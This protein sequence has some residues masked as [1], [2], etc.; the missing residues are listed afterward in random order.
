MSRIT[1]LAPI[2]N[3]ESWVG[4][5]IRSLQAQTMK[6]FE[7]LFIDDGSTDDTVAVIESFA[8]D[9]KRIKVHQIPTNKGL[10]N[11]WN[12]G[13]KLVTTPLIA[14]ASGDDIWTPDRAKVTCDYFHNNKVDV[15]Y[16]SF[17]FC[18]SMMNKVEHKPAIAYDKKLLLTPRADGFCPQY[19]GHFV[20]AYTTKIALK[21]PY[22]SNLKVGIDYPFLVDLANAGAKFGWTTKDLGYARVLKSGVSISRRNE[23]EKASKV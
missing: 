19:I 13:T 10:G 5:T 14:V 2:Y 4:D 3:K 11:A 7:V 22:R 12:V 6:D 16:S 18:D 8:E 1:F 17:W 23:V 20:M 15:F 9:D 21:V